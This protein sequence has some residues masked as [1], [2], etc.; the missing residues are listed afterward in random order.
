M[1]TQSE[2]PL[3]VATQPGPAYLHR[4]TTGQSAYS[5]EAIKECVKREKMLWIEIP[6]LVCLLRV[7]LRCVAGSL[8]CS[9]DG[10]DATH[11]S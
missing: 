10:T 3:S 8:G 6:Y 7:E 11:S 2:W 4:G 1:L 9:V 5:K